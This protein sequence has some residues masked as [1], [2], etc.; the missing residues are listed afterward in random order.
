[1]RILLA[2]F[3]NINRVLDPLFSFTL[4]FRIA[5]MDFVPPIIAV[6]YLPL[7]KWAFFCSFRPFV[8]CCTAMTSLQIQ[9]KK[10][11]LTII[12]VAFCRMEKVEKQNIYDLPSAVN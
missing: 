1:M 7:V 5:I 12:S 8:S 6:V 11:C 2:G 4:S 10:M 9:K 3:I